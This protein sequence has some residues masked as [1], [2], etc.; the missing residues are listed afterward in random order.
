MDQP[1]IKPGFQTGQ[2]RVLIIRRLAH[3]RFLI[4][5]SIINLNY[6]LVVVTGSQLVS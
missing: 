3:L 5:I 2:V 1:G 6:I 4:L